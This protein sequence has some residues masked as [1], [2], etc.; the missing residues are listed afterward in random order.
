[1]K[2]KQNLISTFLRL[3]TFTAIGIMNTILI[4]PEDIGTWKNY[5]GYGLLFL[6][7]I[8]AIFLL[9]IL[10]KKQN[11]EKIRL[12]FLKVFALVIPF[13]FIY[14]PLLQ[15]DS[16]KTEY[17]TLWKYVSIGFVAYLIVFIIYLISR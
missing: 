6:A 3:A 8:D 13:Y 10:I 7:V 4:R 5:L 17:K 2:Y 12:F 15:D 14:V 9:S 11:Y 16:N 1:M